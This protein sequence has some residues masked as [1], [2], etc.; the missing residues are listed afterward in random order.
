MMLRKVELLE[1][2]MRDAAVDVV[3][4]A[5][6]KVSTNWNFPL[7]FVSQILWRAA[8]A[9]QAAIMDHGIVEL[10]DACNGRHCDETPGSHWASSELWNAL[11]LCCCAC[12][13]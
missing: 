2:A 11:E 4:V 12:S 13:L 8:T 3:G 9:T 1:N 6:V 7:P 5:R 10:H